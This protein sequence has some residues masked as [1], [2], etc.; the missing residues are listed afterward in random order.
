MG[1]YH[2]DAPYSLP[3][4]LPRNMRYARILL[5]AYSG[6]ESEMTAV[7]QYIYHHVMAQ[8][9]HPEAAETLRGI[10]IVEMHHLDLLAGCIRMLGLHPTYSF[11]QGTRRVRWNAGFVQYGRNLRDMLE[12]D[13][14]AEYCAIEE[15]ENIIRQI[16]EPA[17]QQL[18]E[19]I[20]EDERLHILLLEALREQLTSSR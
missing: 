13:I 6:R 19:R 16:P 15:Y 1:Q 10:A 3:E 14:R 5:S 8:A 18:M 4:E 17:I 2:V 7:S 11:Y 9:T 20:I 12:L